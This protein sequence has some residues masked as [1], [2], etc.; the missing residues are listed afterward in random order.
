MA[1]NKKNY[2]ANKKLENKKDP[3]KNFK[4]LAQYL[5]NGDE[6]I[7][8]EIC[9]VESEVKS[10][11]TRAL[12]YIMSKPDILHKIDKY[13]NDKYSKVLNQASPKDWIKCYG[14][15]VRGINISSTNIFYF[16]KFSLNPYVEFAKKIRAYYKQINSDQPS[17]Y[18][19]QSLYH[20]YNEGLITDDDLNELIIRDEENKAAVKNNKEVK[21]LKTL[22]FNSNVNIK[23]DNRSI[24][25]LAEPVRKLVDDCLSYIT[26]KYSG[27]KGCSHCELN[28]CQKVILDTNLSTL[29]PEIENL[30]ILFVAQHPF[31]DDL[32]KQLPFT[33]KNGIFV[34]N[35]IASL[36]SKYPTL[37]WGCI[38]QIMCVPQKKDPNKEFD[39]KKCVA[40][41]K[42]IF[43][44]FVEIFKPS[45][46]MTFGN[47]VIKSMNVKCNL[48][49]DSG[50]LIQ[51]CYI[52]TVAL[53]ALGTEK[54]KLSLGKAVSTLIS[55]LE[56][57]FVSDSL[58]NINSDN[59]S[60]N[61][62]FNIKPELLVDYLPDDYTIVDVKSLGTK[63][64]YILKDPNGIKK[65]YIENTKM[66]I[67]IKFGEYKDCNYFASEMDAI[68]RVNSFELDKINKK[69]YSDKNNLTNY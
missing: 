65:Y 33:G 41:C 43:N 16:P 29:N 37:K 27:Y 59:N 2:S 56:T 10:L 51:N 45:F 21:K 32:E 1:Y 69:L 14:Q 67:Y 4:L 53:S 44:K 25:S 57:K 42:G 61:T 22:N 58:L 13:L 55:S 19:I 5:I 39:G 60:I 9:K 6:K 66:P 30:D 38:N 48:R 50:N 15:L 34:R 54:A 24:D 3:Y 28:R 49:S 18:E 46:I 11:S 23:D 12:I 68:V 62:E 17:I 47:D 36:V 8:D 64:V 40:N 7:L 20:L 35:L 63:S 52:P 31:E 26:A